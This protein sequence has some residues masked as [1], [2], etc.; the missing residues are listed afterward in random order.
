MLGIFYN[1]FVAFIFCQW[2]WMKIVLI[3]PVGVSSLSVMM[4]PVVGVFGGMLF[5]GE[6]PHWQDYAALVLVVT[7][8]GTVMMP[9]KPLLGKESRTL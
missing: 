9:A 2:A 3:A 1:V 4:T 6:T 7:S 5:L 8:L